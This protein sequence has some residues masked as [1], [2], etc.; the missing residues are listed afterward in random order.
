MQSG[1]QRAFLYLQDVFGSLMNPLVN[2]IAMH[3]TAG[4]SFKNQQVQCS[5]EQISGVVSL[6]FHGRDFPLLHKTFRGSKCFINSLCSARF[7]RGRE[8]LTELTFGRDG[9]LLPGRGTR[10]RNFDCAHEKRTFL[11]PAVGPCWDVWCWK[12]LL[13]KEVSGRRLDRDFL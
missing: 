5:L 4:Q 11:A 3:G 2:A 8:V 7:F 6:F 9:S 13:G 12:N 10:Y 1:I